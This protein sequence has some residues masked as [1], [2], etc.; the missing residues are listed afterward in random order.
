MTSQIARTGDAAAQ[1]WPAF[2]VSARGL[3]TSLMHAGTTGVEIEFDLVDQVLDMRTSDGRRRQ[4]A[5]VTPEAAYYDHE[6]GEFLLPYAAVRT[7]EHP[8]AFLLS[9]FQSTYEAAAEL[10][11]WD[12][13]ALDVAP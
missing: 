12:R 9:F 2:Y 10:A 7:A 3:T 4:V 8:D 5:L 13:A 1:I 11:G 6:M